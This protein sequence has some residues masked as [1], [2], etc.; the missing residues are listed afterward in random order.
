MTAAL[1]LVACIGL[2][3]AQAKSPASVEGQVQSAADGAPL[4]GAVVALV[5]TGMATTA[6]E[7]GRY[8]LLEVPP[9][10]RS[11][12]ATRIGYA[13]L[14][15]VLT[16]PDGGRLSVDFLLA[17]APVDLPPVAASTRGTVRVDSLESRPETIEPGTAVVRLLDA[18]PGVAETGIAATAQALL[19]TDPP[20]PDNILYVRGAGTALDLVL[21]DGAPVH[22]P[23]HLGGLLEPG[24]PPT[25]ERATR[26]QGGA[27]ARFDGGL[28][29]VLRLESRSGS[30]G[31]A[32]A[33]MF[34]DLI[35]AGAAFESG[36]PASRVLV[37]ARGLHGYGA[38]GLV[39]GRFPQRYADALGRVDVGLTPAD[40][41]HGTGFWNQESV[42]LAFPASTEGPSTSP[43]WGNAA[44][45][46]RY[47]R[48]L[49]AGLLE[50]GAAMGEFRT[51]LP[52]GADDPVLADGRTLRVRLTVDGLADR[53]RFL[54]GYGVHYDRLGL[55]TEFRGRQRDGD[56]LDIR[57]DNSAIALAGYLDAEIRI[58]PRVRVGAGIRG[59]VFS[60]RLGQSLSPR[61][62]LEWA[63][64]PGVSVMISAG[65]FHQLVASA[66]TD[67]PREAALVSATDGQLGSLFTTVNVA[68]SEHFVVGVSHESREGSRLAIEGYWKTTEGLPVLR[69]LTLENAGIDFWVHQ[70]VGAVVL[71]GTYS[72]AWAWATGPGTT[73][74]DI[75]SG[76]HF[77]R[78]GVAT[79]LGRIRFAT[80]L[81]FGDGLE[82]GVIPRPA[83]PNLD[84]T[85]PEPVALRAAYNVPVSVPVE[86]P[87]ILLTVP[88]GE[89]LRLNLAV[90]ARFDAVLFGRSNVFYPYVKLINALDRP[91]AMFYQLDQ[92]QGAQPQPVGAIPLIP[93]VGVEWRM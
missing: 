22:A 35:S 52:I 50:V 93:V 45:S 10:E 63:P 4:A 9:G 66:D 31:R 27:P 14:Q 29:D 79:V 1:A 60:G 59:N 20:V 49:S 56:T 76:R 80:D 16:V 19:G 61:G 12:L 43:T 42:A 70:D 53:D 24:L 73:R 11:I 6:D 81:A 57:Q 48:K 30:A 86:P 78:A 21:L 72:M 34:A 39:E 40:S 58:S 84:R 15:V 7:K 25:V 62:R 68:E 17:L 77:L 90:T 82:F 3:V 71:W 28:A 64:S 75:F 23:Y 2:G 89:Y 47:R 46:L 38:D 33:S 26:Y 65:R 18:S 55:R 88:R 67:L 54:I 36:L 83:A 13:P 85:A 37:A 41:L 44:G 5:G 74:S 32:R 51:R 87:P 92:D 8:V 69:E 91:D